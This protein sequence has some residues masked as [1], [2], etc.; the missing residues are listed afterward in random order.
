MSKIGEQQNKSS[1]QNT[2]D[3]DRSISDRGVKLSGPC[4]FIVPFMTGFYEVS[5]VRV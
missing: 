5:G 1:H 2:T 3:N 4:L